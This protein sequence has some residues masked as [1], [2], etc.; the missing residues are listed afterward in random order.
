[1]NTETIKPIES[2]EKIVR[3]ALCFTC[4][5]R[6]RVITFPPYGGSFLNVNCAQCERASEVLAKL[7]KVE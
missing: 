6:P 1:M 7:E 4:K 5:Q 2:P 3:E